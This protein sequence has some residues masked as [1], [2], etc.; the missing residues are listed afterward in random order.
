MDYAQALFMK[1]ALASGFAIP[2]VGTTPLR[3]SRRIRLLQDR[4]R[5]SSWCAA[6]YSELSS[7]IARDF[8]VTLLTIK[9]CVRDDFILR[10]MPGED[11]S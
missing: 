5:P 10:L 7:L 2:I 1:H 3:P 6:Q 4:V 11:Q 8:H 9:V